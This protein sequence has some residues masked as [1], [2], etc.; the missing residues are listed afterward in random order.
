MTSALPALFVIRMISFV[1]FRLF[2]GLWKYTSLWDLRN[3][4]VSIAVST[5]A[6]AVDEN[7]GVLKWA[8]ASLV[9]DRELA[10]SHRYGHPLTVLRVVIERWDIHG[11]TA[12]RGEIVVEKEREVGLEVEY[13]QNDGFAVLRVGIE[14]SEK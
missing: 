12:D 10:R 1:P 13:F 11:P 3:I 2:E 4:V 7:A 8:H 14:K 5:A 6:M 9:F